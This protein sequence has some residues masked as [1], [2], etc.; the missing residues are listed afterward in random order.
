MLLVRAVI[1]IRSNPR[2]NV[3]HLQHQ[4]NV[5]TS[6]HL[7]S[8]LQAN[9]HHML[10]IAYIDST[11]AHVRDFLHTHMMPEATDEELDLVLRYYPSWAPAGCP[12]DTGLNNM[13]GPQFK[14]I[15]AIQGDFV[16][17]G[18]RRMILK[19]PARKEKAWSFRKYSDTDVLSCC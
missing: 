6:L 13:L 15:A 19:S 5:R 11:D 8:Y 1:L 16:F 2:F 4:P 17:H 7:Q 12:F 9:C 3:L 10:M 18:P 14:R